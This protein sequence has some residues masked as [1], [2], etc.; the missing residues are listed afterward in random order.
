[1]YYFG[2]LSRDEDPSCKNDVCAISRGGLEL[3]G[4]VSNALTGIKL[5]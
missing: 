2:A 5:K 3:K 4:W 1:M